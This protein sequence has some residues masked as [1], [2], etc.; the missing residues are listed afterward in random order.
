MDGTLYYAVRASCSSSPWCCCI[1]GVYVW[2]NDSQG[3]G[4]QA[5]RA[6]AAGDVRGRARRRGRRL[7]ILKQ[8][9]L[10]ESPA[11]Q[12]VLLQRAADPPARPA[13]RAVGPAAG[14]SPSSCHWRC[15]L[16]VGVGRRDR[17]YCSRGRSPL[18]VVAGGRRRRCCRW[19]LVDQPASSK[20][21]AQI[22]QQLPDALDLMG[23]ALR[24][25][26]ALPERAADGRRRDG[27]PDRRRVPH[28]VRRGQLRHRDEGCAAQ[29]RERA[30]R[31]PTCAT[32]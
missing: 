2:W 17:R 31:S 30:C 29:S 27:R 25:G 11:L 8:R 21:L 1:E 16:G 28:R 7:S 24:A 20:R 5:H 32:S 4:G 13:A 15:M 23:R 14:A 19:L 12:R 22:D 6:A 18:V 9:L 10:A 3:P 26:H